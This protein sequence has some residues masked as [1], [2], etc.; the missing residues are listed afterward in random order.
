MEGA[1]GPGGDAGEK[2]AGTGDT[3]LAPPDSTALGGNIG[4]AGGCEMEGCGT[5]AEG[6]SEGVEFKPSVGATRDSGSGNHT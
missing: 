1:E 4:E 5:G 2:A 3:V 6:P